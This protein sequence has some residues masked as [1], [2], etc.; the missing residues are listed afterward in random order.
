MDLEY[1]SDHQVV[2]CKTCQT[3]VGPGRKSIET[4]LRSKPHRFT[5]QTL[6]SYLEFTDSL[7]LH[8]LEELR[9]KKPTSKALAIK[10]LK[11]W[12]GYQCLLCG[13]GEFLTSHFPRMRDH[14][15]VHG[16]KAKEHDKTPLW[17]ECL[18]QSY[19]TTRSRIDY[20]VVTKAG[21]EDGSRGVLLS[22][23][24]KDL[25][26]KLEK[27]YKDIKVDIEEQ[28]G[29]VYDIGDSRSE[30]VPWLHDLTGFPYHISNLKGEEIWSSY[31][32]PPKKEL[33]SSSENAKDPDLV[34][35]LVA[36]E[37]MLRDAYRLCSN[38]SP[39]RKMTQ[40]R[41]NILNEFYAGASGKADGFRY[42]KNASTLVTYF[43]T[44]KQLLVYY[45]RV[46]YCEDGHFTRVQP[47]QTLPKD[48]IQP[49]A[50]QGQAMDEII[51]ALNIE[52]KEDA[53]LAL[54]LAIRRLYLALICHI[55]GS[56]PFESPV[57]SFCA[58]L[59][60]KVH[61]KDRGLWEEPGNFNSH[62][63]A[64]TWTAQLVIFDY[65]CFQEQDDENQIPVFL[66]KICKR[67]F[68]QLAETPFG[69]ILQWRLYLFKVGKEAIVK[70]QARWLLDGQSVEY[71]GV[72][73]QLLQI[74]DLVVSEYQHAH[75]LLY[76]ELLFQAK[77]LVPMESWRLKDDLDL[78]DFGG[79]WLSHPSNSEFLDS[80]ELALF[81]RIQSHAE[82]RA[83]FLTKGEDGNIILCP[84]AM[85]IY[86][87]HAQNFL[88]HVLVLCHIPPGPPLR[89]PELLSVMWRNTARQRHLFIWE[90]LVM[91]YT[92]YHKGQQQFGTYKNNIRSLPKAIGDLL[93]V[94]IAYVLPLRQMF[95]RQHKL[96]AIISPYLWAKL[97]GTVWPD[98]S[99]SAC[100]RKACTRAKIPQ[101]QSAWWRQVAASITKEKFSAK[102]RANF[103]LEDCVGES[104]E[105]ELDLIA[106][107]EQS[108]HSY[109]TF[110]H[111]Y[112][113]TTTLTMSALLHRSYRAS[114]SWRTFFRFDHLLQGK[115]PRGSSETLSLRML[116]A[117]KRGQLCRK[118]AYSEADLLAVARKLYNDPVLQFRAPGQRNGVLAIMGPQPA[119]QV[120]L[121]LGTG[122]GKTLVVMISAAIAG[123][124]TTILI[125][126]TVA[127]RGDMIGRFHQVGIRPLVWSIGCKQSASLVIVSAEAACTQSFLEYCHQEVSKQRLERI[128]VDEAHLT[129]TA[130][131]YRPCM[132]Q[133][134]WY[135]RQIRTQTVWMTATLP[136]V[137]QEE[138]LEHNKLVKPQIIRESTNRPNIRYVVTREKG[139][140]TLVEKAARLVQLSWSRED[141]FDHQRDKIILYCRTREDVA[142][143]VD[144]LG[145]PSYT[146]TSG[147]EEEKK[148]I[149]TQWLSTPT[150][151]A[152]AATSALGP[153]F[154]HPFIRWVIHINAP[155]L[156]SDFSQESGRAGRDGAKACSIVMIS[157]AW[158]PQLET[159]LSPDQEAMQLYLTQQY[160]SR[161]I[162][163]QFLDTEPHWRWCMAEDEVCQVCS[164]PHIEPRPVK[165]KFSFPPQTRIAFTGPE[166]I[167]RQDHMRDQI[168]DR[169]ENDL[170]TMLGT[171]LFCRILCRK[172]NHA[173]QSC[174]RRFSWI[175]A[176]SDAYQARKTEGKEWIQRYV[177]CWKCY[178]PQDLCRAADPEHKEVEC[179]FPDM[180]MPLC[181]G[182]YYRPG[183]QAWLQK[184]FHRA[185]QTEL[186]YMLWLGETADLCG[187]QCIQ[188][189]LV[190][191]RALAE[192]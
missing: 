7:V 12:T 128:V 67:F 150:Q 94:Y 134:G 123:A 58:M 30:R 90:K 45:Y 174:S 164:K 118:G 19:F 173:P 34:R 181:Y 75:G 33:D 130:S 115:R 157:Q 25:F 17:E 6:K 138:F 20:F 139:A 114:D 110:N 85:A 137:T 66:A 13:A 29:I 188:A 44:M 162:L 167:L 142:Q 182:V 41:A 152:L 71:R 180:I 89:E 3:S 54:K 59:S 77:D 95:L 156:M 171:C 74:S 57:L 169:Y 127:L 178:Q 65:A 24:E 82:L 83:M 91:I 122:A 79:S 117:S 120:I 158:K 106:L 49:T 9:E 28:A 191:A 189:N 26:V 64:L 144:L 100:L 69:H 8:S 170:E 46:I 109:H 165:L 2:V 11:L 93:L 76:D 92:Q 68:Q 18:L 187:T 98:G 88:K 23:P 121:V 81:R 37:A 154:D 155:G 126:P 133:L 96:G 172:F 161:G 101:F 86:E 143:L 141:L 113:G 60:R 32:L 186:A 147:T 99:V 48:V 27:D 103:D 61:G 31:K 36:A 166:E 192:F 16:K 159:P 53:E 38:T 35:I 183:G 175:H 184:H 78:E 1:N 131:D 140:G 50:Q 80:A 70:K 39:D 15:V 22:Q 108:N 72:E 107:A 129:V 132:G 136:P 97:D 185:F 47:D 119:E 145:C 111:A 177:T 176:K 124:G 63:S 21:S 14:M 190:A 153:G 5:G 43:T 148:L 10:H 87:S 112:A 73:L 135:V 42:F 151:P 104:I 146:S 52:D 105:D 51:E 149:I 4:H 160:C 102:E 84:R 40:Q 116:D 179:R 163:S 55:V 62:L 56:V 125:L 168:L